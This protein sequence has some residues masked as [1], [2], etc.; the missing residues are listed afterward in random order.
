MTFGTI[1]AVIVMLPAALWPAPAVAGAKIAVF[2]FELLDTSLE[3]SMRGINDAEARRLKS[4]KPQVEDHLA[5]DLGFEPVDLAP[6]ASRAEAANLQACG[7][8]DR[9]LAGT[10]GAELSLTGT[11][12][13][14]SNLILN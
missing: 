8:C 9:T 6:V 11:V 4:L 2:G 3:G 5:H 13:K 10:L 7:G 12:Q 1:L 14:V